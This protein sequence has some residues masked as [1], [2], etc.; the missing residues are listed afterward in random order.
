MV[1][2]FLPLS[3]H[4]NKRAANPFEFAALSLLDYA[5]RRVSAAE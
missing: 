1:S 3:L 5:S 2:A 4:Q